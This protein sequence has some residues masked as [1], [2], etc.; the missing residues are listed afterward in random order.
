MEN[1]R[2]EKRFRW[3]RGFLQYPA[4]LLGML[5]CRGNE[6]FRCRFYALLLLPA[7][8]GYGLIAFLRGDYALLGFS[9]ATALSLG[10]GWQLM[11]GSK[12]P[13]VPRCRS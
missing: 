8:L 13:T 10:F 2:P 4:A 9:S 11:P 12:T 1:R 3:S 5:A 7:A 6:D